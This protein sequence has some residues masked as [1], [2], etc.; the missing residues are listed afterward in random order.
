MSNVFNI[1]NIKISNISSNSSM[2]LGNTIFKG[3]ALDLK[4]IGGNSVIGDA[5]PSFQ[6]DRNAVNDSDMIDHATNQNTL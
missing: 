3:N 6:V 2:N 5:S 4:T 1:F